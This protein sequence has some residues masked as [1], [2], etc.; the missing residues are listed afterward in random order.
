MVGIPHEEVRSGLI[1]TRGA[2]DERILLLILP[3]AVAAQ[4]EFPPGE[5]H[6]GI[7]LDV[8]DVPPALQHE[9]LQAFLAQLLGSPAAA[10]AAADNDGVIL[11]VFHGPTR[12][13]S[14]SAPSC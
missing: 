12:D 5:V 11:D 10:D 1:A 6:G 7:V 4:R 9:G 3:A 8:L 13:R 2:R 14:A